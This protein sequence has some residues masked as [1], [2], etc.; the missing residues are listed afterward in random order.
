MHLSNEFVCVMSMILEKEK[1]FIIEQITFPSVKINT[2]DDNYF[3]FLLPSRSNQERKPN[4]FSTLTNLSFPR[5]NT[6]TYK[7][8]QQMLIW[9]TTTRGKKQ[10][11]WMKMV[12][13][14]VDILSNETSS[15]PCLNMIDFF[16]SLHLFCIFSAR[17]EMPKIVIFL[18]SEQVKKCVS[19][20]SIVRSFLSF[21]LFFSLSLPLLLL[22]DACIRHFSLNRSWKYDRVN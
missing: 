18:T 20:P 16:F 19:M 1:I 11:I 5:R 4:C 22:V 12:M 14:I 2:N 17:Y 7:L 13:K 8:T 15:I 10:S 9:T 3:S 21:F 6:H